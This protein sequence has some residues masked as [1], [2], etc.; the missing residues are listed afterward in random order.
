MLEA[1]NGNLGILALSSVVLAAELTGQLFGEDKQVAVAPEVV[2]AYFAG[3]NKTVVTFVGYSDA[4]YEDPKRMLATAREVLA[5]HDPQTT[6]VNIGATPSG[7]GAVYELAKSMGFPTT[8]IVS[9]E[10]KKYEAPVSPHCDKVFYVKDEGWGGFV[11]G[12]QQLS[13]TS[14]AMVENS[15][16]LIGIGGGQVG[17]DELAAAKKLGKEVRF[18]PADMNH[19]LAIEKAK[20]KGQPIPTDFRGAAHQD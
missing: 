20:K 1:T 19:Q 9:T 10:A 13:P 5:K 16:L 6:I 2:R 12:T 8:G 3:Q 14:Q 7:I 18:F 11:K 15:S 4:G 17:A